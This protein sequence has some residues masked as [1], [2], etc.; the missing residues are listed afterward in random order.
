MTVTF[1]PGGHDV[2]FAYSVSRKVGTAVVRN[3]CA[4]ASGRPHATST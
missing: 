2:R 1:V 4:V 3:R